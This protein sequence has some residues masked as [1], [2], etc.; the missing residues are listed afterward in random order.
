M[1]R[2]DVYTCVY[3]TKDG[4]MGY[5]SFDNE[6]SLLEL[7]N[8]CKENGDKILDACKVEDR[9]EFKDG[10]FESKYQR[11]YGYAIIKALKDKNWELSK[12]SREATDEMIKVDEQ[13]KDTNIP[14]REYIELQRMEKVAEERK[15]NIS[16]TKQIVREM[17]DACYEA[18]WECDDKINE[19]KI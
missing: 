10:K 9:Y 18:V 13:L 11:M 4:E 17:L 14:Y 5:A 6:K 19:T 1:D 16:K 15:E 12:L 3:E 7:L 8:E 2:K